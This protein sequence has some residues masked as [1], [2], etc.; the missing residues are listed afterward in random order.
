[1]WK[2]KAC[3][4]AEMCHMCRAAVRGVNASRGSDKHKDPD[5]ILQTN[6]IRSSLGNS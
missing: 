2:V 3:D 6:L 5:F 4:D 1:M